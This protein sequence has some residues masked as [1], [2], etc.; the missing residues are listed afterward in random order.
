MHAVPCN[1]LR[2]DRSIGKNALDAFVGAGA[3]RPVLPPDHLGA[4]ALYGVPGAELG[5]R[6][7]APQPETDEV[8]ARG[9]GPDELVPRI[10]GLPQSVHH[11]YIIPAAL[12]EGYRG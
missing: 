9:V 8:D 4:V 6:R 3:R 1:N 2:R 12:R 10:V 11:P 5:Q 7:L